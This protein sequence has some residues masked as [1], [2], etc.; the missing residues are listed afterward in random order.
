MHSLFLPMWNSR[1]LE[2]P[3]GFLA[4]IRAILP[5]FRKI[6]SLDLPWYHRKS[7]HLYVHTSRHSQYFRLQ[8]TQIFLGLNAVK[9]YA[10]GSEL[11]GLLTDITYSKLHFHRIVLAVLFSWAPKSSI[12][13]KTES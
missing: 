11:H 1:T 8:L 4:S 7:V 5:Q 9:F 3:P 2:I 12:T 10:R 6:M 13:Q